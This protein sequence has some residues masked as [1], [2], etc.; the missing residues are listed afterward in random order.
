[1]AEYIYYSKPTGSPDYM[2]EIACVLDGK[3]MGD[4]EL[5]LLKENLKTRGREFVRVAKFDWEKPDFAG[6][7]NI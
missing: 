4:E 1:M 2:E 5:E 3:P 7:V 6:A